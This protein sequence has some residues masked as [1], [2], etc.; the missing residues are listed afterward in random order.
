VWSA[1][2]F[3]KDFYAKPPAQKAGGF[4][5]L[6]DLPIHKTTRVTL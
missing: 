2:L 4:F 1:D 5:L 3:L 6:D